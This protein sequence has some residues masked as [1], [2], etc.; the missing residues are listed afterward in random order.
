MNVSSVKNLNGETFS[1]VQD[2]DLTTVVQTNS[3]EWD[4]ISALSG[5][6]ANG[7]EVKLKTGPKIFASPIV[8]TASGIPTFTGLFTVSGDKSHWVS[9]SNGQINLYNI[10]RSNSAQVIRPDKIENWNNTTSVV[11]TNSSNWNDITAYQNVSSTYLTAIN[12]P[13]SADWEDTTDVV[14]TNSASWGAG[15]TPTYDYTNNNLISAIDTSG[16]YATSANVAT[17]PLQK[18]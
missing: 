6:S 17:Y 16:L 5:Y 8:M 4:R 9:I 14:Q 11:Q 2:A 7:W 10:N 3:G 1:A 13:E 15:S 12:I 18:A